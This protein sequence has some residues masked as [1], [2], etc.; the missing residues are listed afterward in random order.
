MRLQEQEGIKGIIGALQA[1]IA[2]RGEREEDKK[3]PRVRVTITVEDRVPFPFGGDS[4]MAYTP[5]DA[6]L[7]I[8]EGGR[9]S[10]RLD[11]SSFMFMPGFGGGRGHREEFVRAAV[12][13]LNGFSSPS[14]WGNFQWRVREEHLE[15]N[16]NSGI[17]HLARELLLNSPGYKEYLA[18]PPVDRAADFYNALNCLQVTSPRGGMTAHFL[19]RPI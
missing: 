3:N 8:F 15:E 4:S 7:K 5:P 6:R 12:G 9:E 18:L 13:A 19:I 11:L 2:L 16:Y 1:L 10:L 17:F 14:L